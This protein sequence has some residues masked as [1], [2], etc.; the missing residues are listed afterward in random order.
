MTNIDA[1]R[2]LR[3]SDEVDGFDCGVPALDRWIQRRARA[4]DAC[5]GARTYVLCED[6][7]VVGYFVLA[8]GVVGPSSAA[9]RSRRD[10]GAGIPVVVLRRI[11]VARSH[12]G[13]G[14]GRSLMREAALRVSNAADV[15][16]VRAMVAYALSPQAK[17][18][19]MAV[20]FDAAPTQPL[21]L[22]ATLA[23]LRAALG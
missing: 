20:G 14:L 4:V 5:G 6:E 9:A 19:G 1:P 16:N 22:M 7:R 10:E 2:P 15:L 3:D 12:Q 18:F 13:Q 8:S 23:D 17:A 11:A 21:L